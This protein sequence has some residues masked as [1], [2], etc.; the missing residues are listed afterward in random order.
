MENNV[1]ETKDQQQIKSLL[2]LYPYH[3]HNTEKIAKMIA[4]VLNAQ[5][6]MPEQNK[7]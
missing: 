6:K 1:K 5:I 3:H 7:S 4:K 2:I